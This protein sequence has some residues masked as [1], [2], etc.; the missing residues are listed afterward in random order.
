MGFW[1]SLCG[2]TFPV[3]LSVCG[4]KM[5]P[6]HSTSDRYD[7]QCEKTIKTGVLP[8]N[9]NDNEDE[10]MKLKVHVHPAQEGGFWAEIPALPGCVSEGDDLPTTLAN[11]R[12]AA[13][14][15]MIVATEQAHREAHIQIEEIEL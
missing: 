8:F 3:S 7:C 9:R 14:G 4:I 6:P 13:E 2:D 15:W 5:M 1:P 12:E 10:T 11:I